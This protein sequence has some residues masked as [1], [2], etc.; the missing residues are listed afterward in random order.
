VLLDADTLDV[1]GEVVAP[2][3]AAHGPPITGGRRS[4]VSCDWTTGRTQ[5]LALL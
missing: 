1:V 4:W 5:L 3:D 2:S